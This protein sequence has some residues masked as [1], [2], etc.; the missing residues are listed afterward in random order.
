MNLEEECRA[1]FN[2]PILC[3]GQLVRL[4]GYGEDDSDCYLIV[5]CPS[6]N[7]TP[8]GI[9]WQTGVGGYIYLDRLKGQCEV[10]VSNSEIWDD[11][12]RLENELKLMGVPKAEEF[13]FK[14]QAGW[15][16]DN[17]EQ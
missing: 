14:K 11:F 8:A 10:I 13:L 6:T 9:F 12:T 16:F 3:N 2:E 1:H 15:K 17:N 4:I 7:G 5:H